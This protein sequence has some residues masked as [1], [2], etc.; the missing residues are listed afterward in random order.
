MV[1]DLSGKNLHDDEIVQVLQEHF[2]PDSDRTVEFDL[3]FN[4][5]T[6]SG[7]DRLIVFMEAHANM[8]VCV[9][10]NSFH[11][12]PFFKTMQDRGVDS[13]IDSERLTMGRSP[14]SKETDRLAAECLRKSD[15]LEALRQL[16][17]EMHRR[18]YER[19]AN[20]DERR[21]RDAQETA[22]RR[23]EMDDRFDAKW[24]KYQ[25][26]AFLRKQE[27][28]AMK[29]RHEEEAVER[30]KRHEKEAAEREKE[31]DTLKKANEKEAAERETEFNAT[32]KKNEEEAASRKKE[33]DALNKR[34]DQK[35]EHVY[36]YESNRNKQVE[37]EVRDAMEQ[38]CIKKAEDDDGADTNVLGNEF[39][40]IYDR[41]NQLIVEWDGIVSAYIHGEK[42]LFLIE[43]K[44]AARAN[45]LKTMPER[46]ARTREYIQTAVT[47]D[48]THC[49]QKYA[50]QSRVFAGFHDHRICGVVGGPSVTEAVKILILENGYYL[51]RLDNMEYTVTPP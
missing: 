17:I 41:T 31:L 49:R 10:E 12:A 50:V 13:W 25:E 8:R 2:G 46:I 1:I 44:H 43:S 18:Q 39:H 36:G 22:Q 3:T 48:L 7:L 19:W 6:L 27:L 9:G 40:K 38:Y 29:I 30:K 14:T 26:E 15:G 11:F 23:K 42:L 33:L 34:V 21:K 35:F 28:D 51:V 4:R 20:E 32:R 5:L 24:K 47:E 16:D 37:E 45:K